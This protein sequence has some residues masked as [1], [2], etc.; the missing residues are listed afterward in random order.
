[1]LEAIASDCAAGS[2][3]LK[4]KQQRVARGLFEARTC[5]DH[6]AGRR[7][8]QLRDRLLAAGAIRTLDDRDHELTDPRTV[9]A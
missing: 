4:L 2:G 7:G 6:L 3:S 9:F 8:V 5:Y 1:M